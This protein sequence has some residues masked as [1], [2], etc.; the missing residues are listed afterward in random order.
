[1]G[2]VLQHEVLIAKDTV[3][4]LYK[5]KDMSV[6]QGFAIHGNTG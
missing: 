4:P 1:L 2:F 5:T 3:A 6:A